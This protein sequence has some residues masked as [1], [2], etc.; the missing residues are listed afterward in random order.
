MDSKRITYSKILR[1]R[2]LISGFVWRKSKSSSR[3]TGSQNTGGRDSCIE[4]KLMD[5]SNNICY[6]ERDLTM[7]S[8]EHKDIPARYLCPEALEI[9]VEHLCRF[10]PVTLR[11]LTPIR[12][13]RDCFEGNKSRIYKFEEE[14]IKELLDNW[15]KHSSNS[16][17]DLIHKIK[18]LKRMDIL[19]D[20][21]LIKLTGN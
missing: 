5:T 2:R 3:S 15:I 8:Q 11:P 14:H 9:I 6:E 4:L 12:K 20:E 7:I 10:H 1:I 19:R 21:E 16:I 18:E 17:G 13:I